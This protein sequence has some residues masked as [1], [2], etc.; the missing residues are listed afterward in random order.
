M[1]I[2]III[3]GALAGVLVALGTALFQMVSGKG[4]GTGTVKA[5]TWRI[6]ISM[7][8]FLLIMTAIAMGWITPHGIQP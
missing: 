5:L 7:A 6:G 8:L 2:K 3:L 4:S 1:L